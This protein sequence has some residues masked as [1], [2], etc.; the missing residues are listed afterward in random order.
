MGGSAL[1]KFGERLPVRYLC[2]R[3]PAGAA[4]RAVLCPV[5]AFLVVPLYN[6]DTGPRQGRVPQKGDGPMSNKELAVQLYSAILQSG[7]IVA[8][9]PNYQGT[10]V[11]PSLDDAVNQVAQLTEKLSRIQDN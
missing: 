3:L 1:R 5:L 2:Q 11:L 4:S 10:I 8:S 9:N 6:P 7:A